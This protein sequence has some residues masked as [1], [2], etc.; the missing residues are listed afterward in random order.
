VGEGDGVF[1]GEGGT[2]GSGGGDGVGGVADEHH[3]KP[4]GYVHRTKLLGQSNRRG[5]RALKAS[6]T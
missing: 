6:F 2:L 1:G 3:L 4:Y 5:V